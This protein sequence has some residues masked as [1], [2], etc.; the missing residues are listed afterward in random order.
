MADV[1]IAKPGQ[2]IQVFKSVN[3]PDYQSEEGA[4]VNPDLTAVEG[5]DPKFW[6]LHDESSIIEMTEEEKQTVMAAESLNRKQAADN[7]EV[8]LKT[9]LTALIK[10][11]NLRLP[12]DQKITKAEVVNALKGEIN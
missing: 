6:K 9:A 2:K 4:I 1:V 8:D 3:T 10:V 5:I 12:K 7:Y 11:I